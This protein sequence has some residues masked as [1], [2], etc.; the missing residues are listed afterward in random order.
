LR[1][2]FDGQVCDFGVICVYVDG[3]QVGE[4]LNVNLREIV[5]IDL[6]DCKI[7]EIAVGEADHCFVVDGEVVDGQ[8]VAI[9]VNE[10]RHL[11]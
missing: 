4:I 3:I 7:R 1:S 10:I 11:R 9:E 2:V 5:A 8:V 6:K